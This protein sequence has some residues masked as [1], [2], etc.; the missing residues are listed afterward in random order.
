VLSFTPTATG[1]TVQF[2]RAVDTGALNLY[3]APVAGMAGDAL[4]GLI[5]V[6]LTGAD[7]E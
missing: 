5:R 6:R 3:D 2:D 4:D 7:P 1:F